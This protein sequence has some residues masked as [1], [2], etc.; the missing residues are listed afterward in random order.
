MNDSFSHNKEFRLKYWIFQVNLNMEEMGRHK[1]EW[2]MVKAVYFYDLIGKVIKTYFFFSLR[3]SPKGG[4]YMRLE[5]M[6]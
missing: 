3:P 6:K 2:L 5:I 4:F 1:N